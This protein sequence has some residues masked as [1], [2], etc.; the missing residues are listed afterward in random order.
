[1]QNKCFSAKHVTKHEKA[2]AQR[3]G[4]DHEICGINFT[5]KIFIRNHYKYLNL[6]TLKLK[7]YSYLLCKKFTFF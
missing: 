1:M 4:K 6:N 5:L 3:A 2:L 7:I